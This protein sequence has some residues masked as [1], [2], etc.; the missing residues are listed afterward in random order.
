MVSFVRAFS[1]SFKS[2][3]PFDH[4]KYVTLN[5]SFSNALKT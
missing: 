1:N 3:I 5:P 4:F 2:I